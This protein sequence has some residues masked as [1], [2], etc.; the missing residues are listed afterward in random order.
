MEKIRRRSA[1]IIQRLT[2]KM[3]EGTVG[4]SVNW[5]IYEEDVPE[6]VK[7]WVFARKNSNKSSK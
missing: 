7:E 6:D 5:G 3:L 1:K 2:E 4:E